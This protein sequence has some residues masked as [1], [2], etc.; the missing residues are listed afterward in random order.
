MS[1]LTC[2]S[3]AL[4][5]HTFLV[6]ADRKTP[7]NAFGRALRDAV[8]RSSLGTR[9]EFLRRIGG[10]DQSNFG[11]YEKEGGQSPRLD[12]IVRWAEIIGCDPAE[13]VPGSRF[14]IIDEARVVYDDQDAIESAL[15]G[16]SM[17]PS[18]RHRFMQVRHSVGPMSAG[19]MGLMAEQIV[20]NGEY[21]GV[22]FPK[23][24]VGGELAPT[25][26]DDNDQGFGE[27]R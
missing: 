12:Q 5:P 19:H 8:A 27:G 20:K 25:G 17:T 18:Q 7:L 15:K 4:K 11:R 23:T 22:A 24:K 13:L 3:A 21:V 14:C 16:I 10:K 26:N 1:E 6:R 9:A 2:C